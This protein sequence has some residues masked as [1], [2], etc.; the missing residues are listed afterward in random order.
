MKRGFTLIELLASI[1]ILALLAL[2]AIPTVSKQIKD[3]KNNL[4]NAQIS[5]IKDAAMAFG[6]DNVFRLPNDGECITVTLGFLKT[7]G[8]MDE[9]VVDPKTNNEFDNNNTFVNIEKVG[10]KFKY[11]VKT[12]GEKCDTV[13]NEIL[14]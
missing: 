8:Y 9:S 11:N 10:N 1:T 5:N 14:E 7:K 4:Y 13:D 6:T 3:S 12:S 2:I